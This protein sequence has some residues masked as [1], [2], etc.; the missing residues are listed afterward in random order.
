MDDR[1]NSS[2]NGNI[3]LHDELNMLRSDFQKMRSI[4]E[5]LEERFTRACEIFDSEEGSR[6]I[7]PP[8]RA[9]EG[10]ST[11]EWDF[12]CHEPTFRER[13]IESTARAMNCLIMFSDLDCS[14]DAALSALGEASRA[15]QNYIVEYVH[16]AGRKEPI[17]MQ[18][19][20]WINPL[21]PWM[22]GVENPSTS[23]EV[24]FPRWHE[25][26]ADGIPVKG[27][28]ADFPEDEQLML[29]ARGIVST[30]AVPILIKGK[31]WGFL[32]FDDFTGEREWDENDVSVLIAAA[33][34]IGNAIE[35]QRNECLLK[36][37]KNDAQAASVAKSQFLASM[38]HEI[39]TPM[40]SIIGLTS[41]L[42]DTELNEKQA[43]FARS[44][45]SSGESLLSLINDILDFSKIE[46]D[47]LELEYEPF[48]VLQ[49]A[50]ETVEA[51]MAKVL[52][53][54]LE[55]IIDCDPA[56]PLTVLGDITRLRQVLINLVSNAIKFTDTGEIVVGIS[57]EAAGRGDVVLRF[58]VRDSGIGIPPERKDQIFESFTQVDASTTRKYGGTGLGLAICKRLVELMGG[59]I[60]VDSTHGKGS[61]FSFSFRTEMYRAGEERQPPTRL[62]DRWALI[63]AP[64]RVLGEILAKQLRAAG[65]NTRTASTVS[66][67]PSVIGREHN[68][69]LVIVDL[70]KNQESG[71]AFIE[72]FKR[73]PG[74]TP[75]RFMALAPPEKNLPPPMEQSISAFINKPIKPS[76][77]LAVAN[78]ILSGSIKPRHVDTKSQPDR[79]MAQRKPMKILIA[80]DIQV[81]QKVALLMLDRLGYRADV[82][83]NG[84]EAL[85]VLQNQHYDVVLMDLHMPEMDGL[86]AT[87]KIRETLPPERQPVI[88][89][90]TADAF[91]SDLDRC[92]QAG[93]DDFISKPIRAEKLSEALMQCRLKSHPGEGGEESPGQA[94][95]GKDSQPLMVDEAAIHRLRSAFE[96]RGNDILKEMIESYITYST[97]TIARMG[98]ICTESRPGNAERISREAHGIKG[99]SYTLGAMLV[100][101]MAAELE[102]R[103]KFG[104]I[105][106]AAQRIE[107]IRAV[108]TRTAEKLRQLGA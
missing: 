67:D 27:R 2:A 39:R 19:Y 58:S 22:G 72:H 51:F 11:T 95:G 13:L 18:R 104:N 36:Q 35:R 34:A 87:R 74:V 47:H 70:Q 44:I 24:S 52:E 46:S 62:Q 48:N 56:T 16:E 9:D 101:S 60:E 80:E 53:K 31:F 43:D 65:M 85:Q 98:T 82:A 90:V 86:E 3:C 20:T 81:N 102:Q 40:N 66:D 68:F 94:S 15:G 63:A 41:L 45:R 78:N 64:N 89:A 4:M 38:S 91:S 88:I 32:G 26:L 84:R 103:A 93:M 1:M 77:F 76:G 21:L 107:Q 105:D 23:H 57:G 83:G 71:T 97:E 17:L 25:S 12:T 49:C 54:K 99:S 7:S 42:M 33:G 61:E 100:G 28:L 92:L 37:A 6:S 29:R 73:Q 79:D 108:F 14:I 59:S 8:G 30:L 10:E 69:D 96:T 75:A 5:S 50:E 106:D 55:L